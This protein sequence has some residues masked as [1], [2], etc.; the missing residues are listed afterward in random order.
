MKI[1]R[2]SATSSPITANNDRDQG[3]PSLFGT[4]RSQRGFGKVNKERHPGPLLLHSFSSLLCRGAF[5]IVRK[6]RHVTSGVDYAAK[7]INT[8]RLSARGE[9]V[10]NNSKVLHYF[11]HS[12]YIYIYMCIY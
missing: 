9:V 3:R 5:S 6:V 1:A 7:I 8:K 4:V 11:P 10:F 12:M 2:L